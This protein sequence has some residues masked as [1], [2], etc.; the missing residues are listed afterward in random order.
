[1]AVIGPSGSGK[2]SLVRAGLLPRLARMP[3]RWLVVPPMRP[4][5]RPTD[6]LVRSLSRIF[7]ERG[8]PRAASEIAAALG[9]GP[10]GL[11]EIAVQLAECE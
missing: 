4:W 6:N 1:V 8:Y 7:N 9:K 5:R 11:V 2:S 3:K 10:A